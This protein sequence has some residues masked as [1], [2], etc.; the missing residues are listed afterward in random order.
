[1]AQERERERRGELISQ[2]INRSWRRGNAATVAY[3]TYVCTQRSSGLPPPTERHDRYKRTAKI[4]KQKERTTFLSSPSPALC[5]HSYCSAFGSFKR[6]FTG[7]EWFYWPFPNQQGTASLKKN[8]T[9][10][11]VLH[12]HSSSAVL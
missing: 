6:S 10:G 8:K 9:R 12:I 3:C 1:M 2:T 4:K 11:A 5:H 7:T